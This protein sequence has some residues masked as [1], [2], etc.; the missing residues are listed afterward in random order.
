[1]SHTQDAHTGRFETPRTEQTNLDA[2]EG[3]VANTTPGN[4]NRRP[5]IIRTKW[6]TPFETFEEL[7]ENLPEFGALLTPNIFPWQT[8][9]TLLS[10]AE[11]EEVEKNPIVLSVEMDQ[12]GSTINSFQ[13]DEMGFHEVEFRE[14]FTAVMGDHSSRVSLR[15]RQ[16][17][18]DHMKEQTGQ[19]D[20]KSIPAIDLDVIHSEISR[21]AG[22]G[23]KLNRMWR[24][25]WHRG[26]NKTIE[27]L[28]S[29]ILYMNGSQ[30][31]I[32]P[33]VPHE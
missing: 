2:F 31:C 23:G 1:M 10:D 27:K 20:W 22:Y 14:I 25:D 26:R 32:N 13:A 29:N 9:A 7:I 17:I 12:G 28:L 5:W 3:Q 19:F 30:A 16:L 6:H 11:V 33:D 18:S 21:M 4:Q 24:N 8:Y 15:A